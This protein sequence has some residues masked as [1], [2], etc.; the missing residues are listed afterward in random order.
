MKVESGSG[1]SLTAKHAINRGRVVVRCAEQGLS[2]YRGLRC[3]YFFLL[4]LLLPLPAVVQ[5]GL[6]LNVGKGNVFLG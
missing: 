1:I 5:L 4:L 6:E 2:R 3:F